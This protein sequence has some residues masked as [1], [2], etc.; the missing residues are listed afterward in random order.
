M[1]HSFT[2]IILLLISIFAFGQKYGHREHGT[3]IITDF[4]NRKDIQAKYRNTRFRTADINEQMILKSSQETKQ[5]LDSMFIK[6]VGEESGLPVVYY[7]EKYTYDAAGTHTMTLY[8]FYI[9]GVDMLITDKKEEYSYFE[10]GALKQ[11]LS[12]SIDMDTYD[13]IFDSKTDYIYDTGGRLI[14]EIEH[15][16]DMVG[17]QWIITG[18][19]EYVYD[20]IGN[21]TEE[22]EYYWNEGLG[23]YELF[24]KTEYTYDENGFLSVMTDYYQEGDTLEAKGKTEYTYDMDGLLIG[25]ID[26]EPAEEA[27]SWKETGRFEFAY[28]SVGNVIM[29]TGFALDS[30]TMEWVYDSKIEIA[31]DNSFAMSDLVLPVNDIGE[32]EGYNHMVTGWDVYAFDNDSNDWLWFL[33]VDYFYSELVVTT[34]DERQPAEIAVFPNP[35][36]DYVS[37]VLPVR[38]QMA[39]FELYD[40]SGRKLISK[41]VWHNEKMGLNDLM[42]GA[43]IYTITTKAGDKVNGKLLKE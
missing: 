37:F 9:E 31:Y 6:T 7:K 39:A 19:Y 29:E 33:G 27:G 26:A 1:K 2:F 16:W 5:K 21:L 30:V 22:L 23:D 15:Y 20:S 41:T 4:L 18:K 17:Q 32:F 40:L 11:V 8:F 43:Y 34:V 28:D 3:D 25:A 10:N 36:G 35:A 14:E 24:W 13:W 12:Y 38:T 42:P